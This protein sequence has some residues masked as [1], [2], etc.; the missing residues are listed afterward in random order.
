MIDHD[1]CTGA[2]TRDM[3]RPSRKGGP[4]QISDIP[5]PG[6]D[7][8]T[9]TIG[10]N[11]L[12]FRNIVICFYFTPSFCNDVD[13]SPTFRLKLR[14]LK[15]R[16][17]NQVY[18]ALRAAYPNARLVHVGYPYLTPSPGSPLTNCGWLSRVEQRTA[19]DIADDLHRVIDLAT[20]QFGGVDYVDARPAL[21]GHELCTDEPWAVP[22][23]SLNISSEQEHP[24]FD[25]QRALAQFAEDSL[26]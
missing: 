8:V 15:D 13:N 24:N 4:A 25:G 11:D 7:L 10:G 18:P 19:A 1:A 12:D 20:E 17:V 21:Q 2:T 23:F 5:L 26:F 22:P 14:L 9:F 6:V 16:L 3:L